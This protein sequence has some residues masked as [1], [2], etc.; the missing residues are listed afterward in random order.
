MDRVEIKFMKS[1]LASFLLKSI[2]FVALGVC[3]PSGAPLCS[4]DE[5]K[6]QSGH[7]MP[8]DDSSGYFLTSKKI[9]SSQFEI[10]IN[11]S[12][13]TDFKGLLMYVLGGDNKMHYGSFQK[14]NDNFKFQTSI[15]TD[16]GV[17]TRSDSTITHANPSS[18]ALSGLAFI[19]NLTV[20][21]Q[22][23]YAPFRVQ[24]VVS[25]GQNPWQRVQEIHLD[26]QSTASS[27][28]PSQ[29]AS[30]LVP[31]IECSY[32]PKPQPMK[33]LLRCSK[34]YVVDLGH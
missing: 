24:A 22:I 17:S 3:L 5:A 34:V 28:S 6:I 2:V 10:Y 31:T 19:W 14:P 27:M 29:T 4:I 1:T 21:D 7:G 20:D 18:K 30:S 16:E 15:C 25:N 33:K 11:S 8:S 23:S 32:S 13:V 26:I 12:T 9:S